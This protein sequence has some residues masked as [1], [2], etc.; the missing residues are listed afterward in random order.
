MD[1]IPQKVHVKSWPE[2]PTKPNRPLV[3]KHVAYRCGPGR[4][5]ESSVSPGRRRS[6]A[7]AWPS[8]EQEASEAKHLPCLAPT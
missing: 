6:S 1:H 4:P 2:S 3:I 7:T 8:W 5:L